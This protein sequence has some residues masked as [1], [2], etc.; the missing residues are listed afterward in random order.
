LGVIFIGMKKKI[1]PLAMVFALSL[2]SCNL[3]TNYFGE[4][5]GVNL[6]RDYDFDTPSWTAV[7]AG[8][9]VT[10]SDI[11]GTVG[12]GPA[13]GPAYE[14]GIN[15]LYP[16]GKMNALTG[17]SAAG[18]TSQANQFIGSTTIDGTLFPEINGQSLAV[19]NAEVAGD[20]V[21]LN[22]RPYLTGAGIGN[23]MLHHDFRI[24]EELVVQTWNGTADLLNLVFYDTDDGGNKSFN[25]MTDT[26]AN[27]TPGLVNVTPLVYLG[28]EPTYDYIW[29][30]QI[31]TNYGQ[32][33]VVDN[34]RLVKVD[35]DLTVQLALPS[36]T[37]TT[38]S[39]DL[40]PGIYE[41]S[42]NVLDHPDIDLTNATNIFPATGITITMVAETKTG[43][44]TL[45]RY[46]PRP[47]G[48]WGSWT[49][50]RWSQ[51]I[52]FVGTDPVAGN[53]LTISISPTNTIQD[54]MRI[55]SGFVIIADP[56]LQ[57]RER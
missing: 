1:A 22:I 8:S 49:T 18:A 32:K 25:A 50:L 36:L 12:N 43:S 38:G 7:N 23:Y 24:N 51:P 54:E 47:S 48:G 3:D 42:I 17:I 16:T 13:G 10:Y 2:L 30:Q 55:D 4:Y 27:P 46:E 35:E 44:Q 21:I 29:G 19:Y 40:L 57:F 9:L 20:M 14:L 45:R 56:T 52:D 31:G 11:T 39:L 15:N 5:I 53:V 33:T 6:I 28:T 34:I 26:F 41:F 37:S